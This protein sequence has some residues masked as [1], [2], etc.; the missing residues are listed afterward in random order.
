MSEHGSLLYRSENAVKVGQVNRFVITYTP[1]HGELASEALGNKLYVK[2]KNT[3]MMALRAAYLA[4]P[5]ILYAEVRT[6]EYSNHD[7]VF[8]T[9]D[10]PIYEPNLSPGKSLVAELQ[11]HT[12]KPKYVW[13]VD[14]VSQLIF[15]SNTEVNYEF[16]IGTSASKLHRHASKCGAFSES[17]SV[18][19]MDTRD[20]WNTPEKFPTKPVHLVVL[21]HGLHSNSTADMLYMKECIEQRAWGVGDNV[22]VKCYAENVCKTERGIKYLGTRLAEYIVRDL[23]FDK[24]D[25]ISFIAHSLGGLSQT[26][27]IAYIAKNYPWFFDKI[28]PENFVTMASPLLGLMTENPAYVKF[29]LAM[30][31]VGKTGL[32]LGLQGS[33]PLLLVLPTG[34]TRKILKRFKR[35]TVYAN[36]INDGIVPLRTSALLYLDWKGLMTVANTKEG[37]HM[38]PDDHSDNNVGKIPDNQYDVEGDS[39]KMKS[40]PLSMSAVKGKVLSPFQ[41]VLSLLAPSFQLKRAAKLDRFQT[42]NDTD[43][44]QDDPEDKEVSL[45][46][47]PKSSLIESAAS[48]LVPPL[49]PMKYLV[50]PDCREDILLHDKVYNESDL[51]PYIKKSSSF[52]ENLDPTKR[53]HEMEELIAREWHKGMS[54]RKVLVKLKPDAHNN[55]VVRRRFSNAYGWQVVDH[56]VENHFGTEYD[57]FSDV[58]SSLEDLPEQS[59]NAQLLEDVLVKEKDKMSKKCRDR[60]KEYEEAAQ[61]ESDDDEWVNS[62]S[63][64]RAHG[65]INDDGVTGNIG[66]IVGVFKKNYQNYALGGTETMDNEINEE[67]ARAYL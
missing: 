31:V 49:P 54:W 51:P 19:A 59:K 53:Q 13:V 44:L 65:M 27:A 10:Q 7:K 56:L 21:T 52:F 48:I 57:A 15:S 38:D 62:R 23:Y 11:I 12:I 20:I 2:I 41:T 34:P 25:R 37:E 22:V 55:M 61:E 18:D 67:T 33:K 4:G 14:V 16:L 46:P 5:F 17:I 8:V 43:D 36:A 45:N 40:H 28:E 50:D 64:H 35:R 39:S 6:A 63:E 9:A 32:D 1:D 47:L 24:I 26:F 42:K 58:E 66:E 30:G 29:G 60:K 3:E